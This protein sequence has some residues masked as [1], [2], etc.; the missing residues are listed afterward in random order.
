M[1]S[2]SSAGA[3]FLAEW[4]RSELAERSVEPTIATLDDAA[5]EVSASGTPVRLLALFAMPNDD[6]LFGVFTAESAQTV[7]QACERAGMSAQR[8]TSASEVHFRT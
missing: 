6:L 3:C 2:P 4:Y 7:A 1:E 5:A 8:L